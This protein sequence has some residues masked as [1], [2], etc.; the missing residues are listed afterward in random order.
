MP[1]KSVCYNTFM[2]YNSPKKVK[3]LAEV[4][5]DIQKAMYKYNQEIA[6]IMKSLSSTKNLLHQKSDLEEIQSIKAKLRN[7]Q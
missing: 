5:N 7:L 6:S 2:K 3:T 4:Q 1:V